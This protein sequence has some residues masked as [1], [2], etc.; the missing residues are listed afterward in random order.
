MKARSQLQRRA[1]WQNRNEIVTGMHADH[2]ASPSYRQ[3]LL[4]P[5]AVWSLENAAHA[6]RVEASYLATK[7]A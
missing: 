6:H 7:L 5:D 3:P 1:R 4:A 2:I